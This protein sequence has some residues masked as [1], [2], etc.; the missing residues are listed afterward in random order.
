MIP[1]ASPEQDRRLPEGIG[2]WGVVFGL[3]G[4]A[5]LI[6]S[7]DATGAMLTGYCFGAAA[8]LLS[9]EVYVT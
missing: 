6:V 8:S 9:L 3:F 5:G 2:L 7:G 1:E 4:I